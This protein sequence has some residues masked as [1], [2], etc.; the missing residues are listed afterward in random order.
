MR[1]FPFLFAG[2]A[3]VSASAVVLPGQQPLDSDSLSPPIHTTA[4][5]RWDDCGLSTDPV[6]IESI[7][8]SPDPPEPGQDMTVTVKGTAR[9]VIEDGAYADVTVKLGLIKI[10]Q[11]EFDVCEEARNANASVQCP[12]EKGTYVVKQTVALPK[13]IPKAKFTV[14]IQGYTANDDDMLCLKLTVDFMKK[15]FFR[16]W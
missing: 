14:D 13:E 15:P 7:T 6:Q 2:L 8:V 4:G 11:R 10:L 12:V 1:L 9:E 16:P 5:W 3:L